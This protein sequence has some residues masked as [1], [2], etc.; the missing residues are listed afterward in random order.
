MLK[1]GTWYQTQAERRIRVT[2]DA[3]YDMVDVLNRA[4]L[5]LMQEKPWTDSLRGEWTVAATA[6]S[7][8]ITLP[9]DVWGIETVE[10]AN[11]DERFVVVSPRRMVELRQ[12]GTIA[13]SA[14]AVWYV[15][16]DGAPGPTTALPA[17]PQLRIFDTPTENGSPTI[18]I[19]G[20]RGWRDFTETNLAEVP[21]LCDHWHD[22]YFWAVCCVARETRNPDDGPSPDRA[23]YGAAVDRLW[24]TEEASTT[25][26]GEARGGV[27]DIAER[28]V[29]FDVNWT[30]SAPQ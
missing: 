10:S 24:Q 25:D 15:T 13:D 18:T 5:M 6:G 21:T 26:H 30:D 28:P 16:W 23:M 14:P 1:S 7:D 9:R 27:D 4:G 8:R 17:S 11:T 20:K 22:A 19:R 3:D 29:P 2:P 12:R